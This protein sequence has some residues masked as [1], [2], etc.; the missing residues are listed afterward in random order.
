MSDK[1]FIMKLYDDYF[2]LV[3]KTI[4]K[5]IQNPADL[6]DLINDTFLKL[7]EKISLLREFTCHK[8]TAYVVYTSKSIAINYIKHRDVVNK[9][10]YYGQENDLSEDMEDIFDCLED[11]ILHRL[12]IEDLRDTILC[13]PESQR[14]V[15]FFKYFLEMP[16]A[17]IAKTIGISP[18]SVPQYVKR[19][20]NA[21][22]KLFSKEA[23]I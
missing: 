6:D 3:R 18:K 17:E 5:I 4:Y 11:R 8:M 10:T 12:D 14:D 7:I 15:L 21:A 22:K 2:K 9:H 16:D 19:A 1:E 23:C 13:L 20:R